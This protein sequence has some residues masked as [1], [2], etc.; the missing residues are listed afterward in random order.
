[1]KAFLISILA[2]LALFNAS[3]GTDE[4][5]DKVIHVD[6][7][8][9]KMNQAIKAAKKSLDFFFNN[10]KTMKNDGYSLKFSIPTDNND[11]EHIWFNPKAVD[12]DEITAQCAND[13]DNVSN[14]K[15]GDIV[16]LNKKDISDWMIIVGDKCYGGYTIRVL[17][18]KD[19]ASAPEF[20]FID[21]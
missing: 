12:G 9:I 10:Y 6:S 4:K 5:K 14:L 20:E 18:E 8:D 13:P 1:M 2:I 15:A 21:P 17:V 11:T 19:P 16:K 3:C 7:E